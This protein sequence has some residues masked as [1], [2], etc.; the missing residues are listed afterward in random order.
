MNEQLQK[1]QQKVQ[2]ALRGTSDNPVMSASNVFYVFM[3]LLRLLVSY[4][5]LTITT[6]YYTQVYMN[7]VLVNGENPPHLTNFVYMFLIIDAVVFFI[8]TIMLYAIMSTE[9]MN[10]GV[11]TVVFANKVIPDYMVSIVAT[12]VTCS[13]VAN[14]MYEKK[15]FLYKDDGMRA[16]RALKEMTFSITTVNTM[17][18]WNYLVQGIIN[19]TKF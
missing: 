1:V 2:G 12:L 8:L 14:K 18:P 9:T 11:D 4:V 7:K 5:S 16:I 3:K 10:V 19:S 15:Y 17:I 13:I 6:N